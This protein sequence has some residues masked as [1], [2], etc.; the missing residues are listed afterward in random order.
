MIQIP[1]ELSSL[2]VSQPDDR[3]LKLVIADWVSE[4]SEVEGAAWRWLGEK[5][6]APYDFRL[7]TTYY[8]WGCEERVTE[9]WERD[10]QTVPA[11]YRH[12]LLPARVFDR[13]RTG[14]VA[15]TVHWGYG[16]DYMKIWYCALS[17]LVESGLLCEA[18]A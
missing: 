1:S 6:K 13:L 10:L 15:N 9:A 7:H 12:S 5:E 17:G 18:V 16:H 14:H 3:H 8:C 2:L 4:Y 11:N